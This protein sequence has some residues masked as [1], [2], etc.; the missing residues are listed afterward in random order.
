M[1]E[2]HGVDR[3]GFLTI[4][5]PD[6]VTDRAEWQRRWNSFATHYLRQRFPDWLRVVE[7]MRSGRIHAHC[8]VA[9]GFDMR[10][11]FDFEAA[12]AG[13][14]RSASPDLRKLWAELRDQVPRYGF[15]RHELMP[16]RTTSDAMGSYVGKYIGKHLEARPESD[17]GW[18]LVAYG[19]PARVARTRFSWAA[20][21]ASW[22]RGCRLFAAMI[23]ESKGLQAGSLRQHGMAAVLGKRWAYE[24]RET[25][26]AL[27]A[28]EST[29]VQ[30][31][32]P[33]LAAD[34]CD[35]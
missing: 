4:T 15:G 2:R 30:N 23:A 18:R 16:I 26:A 31:H 14:Y 21:G 10:T 6:L 11:G 7:R 13:D 9:V 25:I 12:A 24:W 20:Q 33:A 35:G 8:L 19:S 3:I 27:G 5:P 1:A 22:R 17:K 29:T 28:A 32:L 34:S